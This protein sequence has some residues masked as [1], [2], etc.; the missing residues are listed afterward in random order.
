MRSVTDFQLLAKEDVGVIFAVANVLKRKI[1]GSIIPTVVV[2][3]NYFAPV[4]ED[5][6]RVLA[7]LGESICVRAQRNAEAKLF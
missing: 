4:M 2:A 7:P 3:A 5:E 6:G 1:V